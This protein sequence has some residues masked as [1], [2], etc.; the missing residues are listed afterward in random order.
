MQRVNRKREKLVIKGKLE[1]IRQRLLIIAMKKLWR[2]KRS[3][4]E[5]IK[6][7]AKK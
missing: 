7:K 3:K 6:N 4:F 1:Q 2:K 5:V